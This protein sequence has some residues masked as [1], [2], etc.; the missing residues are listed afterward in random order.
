M[1]FYR[2]SIRVKLFTVVAL[3]ALVAA[4]IGSLALSK[5]A[6]MNERLNTI[7]DVTTERMILAAR[8]QQDLLAIHRAEKNLILSESEE[9]MDEYAGVIEE[10]DASLRGRLDDLERLASTEGRAQV[11]V[12]R[13]S[14]ERFREISE[15]VR[16]ASRENTNGQAFELSANE[17]RIAFDTVEDSL[18]AIAQNNEHEAAALVDELSQN[19]DEVTRRKL[20]SLK[21]ATDRALLASRMVQDATALGR[22]E[23][24]FILARTDEEMRSIGA[25]ID[26]LVTAIDTRAEELRGLAGADGK[27][28]LEEFRAEFEQWK[29]LNDRIQELSLAASNVKARRLSSGEGRDAFANASGAMQTIVSANDE[30][31]V[32][33]KKASDENFAMAR[34]MVIL[35]TTLGIASGVGLALLI[36]NAIIKVLTRVVKRVRQIAD[37]DL[38]GE[39]LK[40]TTKDELGVLTDA[41]NEMN[42]SLQDIVGNVQSTSEQVASA[43]T[44]VSASSEE[45]SSTLT[46]QRSQF[47]QVSAAVEELSASVTEVARNASEAAGDARESGENATEGGEVVQQTVVEIN[48]IAEQVEMTA[49]AVESLGKQAEEIGEII[50]VINEIADQTNLLALNAAIE[51]ARAGEHGRGFAVVAD[52]VRQLA[53]RT[54]TATQQV[55]SSINAIQD[56][57]GS[58]VSQ[59]SSSREKVASGVEKAERAGKSLRSIVEG[60]E[61][62]SRSVSG[63]ASSAEQQASASQEISTSVERV[64]AA[65]EEAAKGAE[66]AAAAATQLSRNAE[67]LQEL[68][69]RFRV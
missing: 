6:G 20:A 11:A 39:P 25:T 59:M 18:R 57:T 13:E 55:T 29:G 31:M 45:M 14:Y 50:G 40:V 7:V 47:D 43:A 69:A 56:E 44:E 19:A 28:E 46:E 24:N 26:E 9:K 34:M 64:N 49:R 30:S 12:F 32:A 1:S 54:T 42:A 5:M 35:S 63:I 48:E 2:K 66:Q 22:A 38:T 58:A 16:A 65:S 27:E 3:L 68:A 36:V 21:R 67:S 10:L 41:V 8:A 15:Q 51:A 52:E 53:E 23:K 37:G 4:G 62:V 33:D 60:S 17:G 61:N